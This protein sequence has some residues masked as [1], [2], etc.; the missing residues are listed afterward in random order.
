[1][2]LKASL[3]L[4]LLAGIATPAFAQMKSGDAMS[5]GDTMMAPMKPMTAAEKAMMAKCAKMTPAMAKKNAKCAKI[6]AMH[7]A[8]QM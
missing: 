1:M 4:A 2:I 3:A 6:A 5:S 8:S 7:P